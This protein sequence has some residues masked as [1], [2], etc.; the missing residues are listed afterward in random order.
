MQFEAASRLI[1]AG[2][3]K[4]DGKEPAA[5]LEEA[6]MTFERLELAGDLEQLEASTRR[7]S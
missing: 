5:L 1:E 6:R 3:A 2:G 4:L 7:P